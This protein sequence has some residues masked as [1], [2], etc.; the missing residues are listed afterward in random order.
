L[1]NPGSANTYGL[2]YTPD[3]VR[4]SS[5]GFQDSLMSSTGSLGRNSPPRKKLSGYTPEEKSQLRMKLARK[6]MVTD[7]LRAALQKAGTNVRLMDDD[8][9][10]FW[11]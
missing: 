3:S 8:D 4:E 10:K 6:K 5:R 1:R 11:G 7:R 2:F 9:E